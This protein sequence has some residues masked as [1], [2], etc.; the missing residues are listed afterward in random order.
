MDGQAFLRE[1]AALIASGWCT[2]AGARNSLG[3]AVEPFDESAIAWSLRGALAVVAEWPDTENDA[4]RDALWGI[5]GVIPDQELDGWNDATGR[6]Q[7]DTLQMLAHADQ[8][9][10]EPT[11]G[12]R[13]V[14]RH[15]AP[16]PYSAT[17]CS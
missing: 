6:T 4:L 9:Q 2:G 14:A 17:Y 16:P 11:A 1:T 3:V 15:L 12:L 10:G 7:D 8:P 13:P 5:S